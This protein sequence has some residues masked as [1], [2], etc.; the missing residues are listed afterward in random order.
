MPL[1]LLGSIN[2]LSIWRNRLGHK[3]HYIKSQNSTL[4]NQR[5]HLWLHIRITQGASKASRI[6][7]FR[8]GAQVPQSW[9]RSTVGS[10]TCHN[11]NFKCFR[12]NGEIRTS[13]HGKGPMKIGW[14]EEAWLNERGGSKGKPHVEVK[15]GVR[16]LRRGRGA[17]SVGHWQ[18]P[19]GHT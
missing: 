6:R 1:L 12:S 8:G 17:S 2:L 7:I 13:W 19:T 15:E 10:N 18:V 5:P 16:G 3:G 14:V 4:P 11:K 9:M